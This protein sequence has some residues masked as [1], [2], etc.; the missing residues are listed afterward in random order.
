MLVI[1]VEVWPGGR[2]DMKYKIGEITAGNV[3]GSG[4][5]GTYEIRVHQ[6]EYREAGVAEISEKLILRDHDRRA[7]PLALV[8]D[9]LLI[10]LPKSHDADDHAQSE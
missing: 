7:G 6:D 3:A 5:I 2:S 8:R 1:T 10:A 9:A 4:P